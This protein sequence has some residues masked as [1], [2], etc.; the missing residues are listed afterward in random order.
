MKPNT[1]VDIVL[2]VIGHGGPIPLARAPLGPSGTVPDHVNG[3]LVF[4]D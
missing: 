2:A 3:L 4:T 1:A